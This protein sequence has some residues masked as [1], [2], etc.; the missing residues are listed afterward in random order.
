MLETPGPKARELAALY[1][2]YG[3]PAALR[4][5]AVGAFGRLAKDDESLQDILI[6]LVDDPDR[7]VRFRSWGV[8]RELK[9]KK[10]YP[11]LKARLGQ[12]ATGFSGFGR[13]MLE[14]TLEALTRSEARRQLPLPECPSCPRSPS[15][16][17]RPPTWKT[18]PA[19]S[20]RRIECAQ[21]RRS[22]SR[23]SQD[24]GIVRFAL[25]SAGCAPI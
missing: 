7:S 2:Q 21:E 11:A 20:G 3:Q 8:I 17:A 22:T 13:R 23:R 10:A 14:E 5:E 25:M 18:R 16:I 19:S 6:A 12:E 24:V 4:S 9:L 1:S 15:S